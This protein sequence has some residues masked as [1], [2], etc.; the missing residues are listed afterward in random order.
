M[1]PVSGLIKDHLAV[2][3]KILGEGG[4]VLLIPSQ[5]SK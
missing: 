4:L 1:F 3:S 5:E 2:D